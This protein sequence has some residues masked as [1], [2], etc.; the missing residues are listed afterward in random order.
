MFI[1]AGMSRPKKRDTV[2]S[3]KQQ[4]LNYGALTLASILRFKGYSVEL[5]HGAHT[6]PKDFVDK[7]QIDGGLSS[8]Y[9]LLLSIPSFYALSWSQKFT[10]E[11]KSRSPDTKIIVGGRW[12]VGSDVK[13][14]REKLPLVDEIVPGMAEQEIEYLINNVDM[15]SLILPISNRVSSFNLNHHLVKNYNNFQPSVE[16]SR[17]CG[18][19]CSFCEERD[20]P[21][22]PLKS[23]ALLASH[24]QDVAKQYNDFSIRP[25]VQSSFF[26]PNTH[27]A[28]KLA[29]E[30][31]KY[32]NRILWR[33]ETRVDTIKPNVVAALAQGGLKVIDLGLES[34][35]PEQ[36]LKMY[37]TS[38]PDKYLKSASDLISA[39]RDNGI[40]VKVNFLLYAGETAKTYEETI[41]WLD[42]HANSI[43]GISVGPVVVFGSPKTSRQFVGDIKQLGASLVDESSGDKGGIMQIHPSN[44]I[45]AMDAETLSLE[46][47]RR[48]MNKIDYFDLKSFSYYPRDYTYS[49]FEAD[50]ELNGS[51]NLPFNVPA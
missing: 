26:A 30:T 1:S 35:S 21:L 2:L 47:S 42:E 5:L 8:K 23:P 38:K 36:L 41:K 12:V 40:W 50:V 51:C 24:L 43:K 13:W 27:W 28:E 19:G 4:Y 37:K 25:Y 18:M 14:L 34:A 11:I 6:E 3:R 20:I 7:L 31:S 9:P 48:Y 10:K 49:D 44:E 17:G 15:S 46:A 16:A 45:S 29:A 32:K 33:C 22:T 39:C